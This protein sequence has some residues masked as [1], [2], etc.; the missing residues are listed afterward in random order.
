MQGVPFVRAK[1]LACKKELGS[2]HLQRFSCS[3]NRS[4]NLVSEALGPKD[5]MTVINLWSLHA[6]S[7]AQITSTFDILW[8][9]NEFGGRFR[10]ICIYIYIYIYM[11][12]K[13]KNLSKICRFLLRKSVQGC[14]EYLSKIFFACF[15]PVLSCFFWWS[16]NTNSASGCENIFLQVIEVSKKGAS[17]KKVHFW[18]LVY[19]QK[20]KYEKWKNISKNA[21]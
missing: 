3:R 16:K 5:S 18:F 19:K 11:R 1:M 21:Q 7:M 15:P 12:C 20:R 4:P 9:I 6:A 10:E 2:W 17:P 13:V 14:V 8:T